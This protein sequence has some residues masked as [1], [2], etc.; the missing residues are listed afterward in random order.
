[1]C[2]ARR[3]EELRTTVQ[4][5]DFVY[6]IA[7]FPR[8]LGCSGEW[9]LVC[10]LR[11][12]RRGHWTRGRVVESIHDAKLPNLEQM[13]VSTMTSKTEKP[14]FFTNPAMLPSPDCVCGISG[15]LSGV[16]EEAC[17]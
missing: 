14:T 13:L 6:I 7:I 8:P 9:G 11:R 15:S 5:D 4:G 12:G 10:S 1:M 3:F 17:P 16:A 2:R